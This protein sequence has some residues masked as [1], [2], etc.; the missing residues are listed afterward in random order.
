MNKIERMQTML[1]GERPDQ[2]PAGFWFHFAESAAAGHAMAQAHIDYYRAADPDLLKVMND[3]GYEAVGVDVV[4]SPADWR[5]LEPAP[6]SSAP[7]QAQLAGLRELVDEL[8]DEVL[9]ATTIFNPY[10]TGNK[11]SNNK[12]TEHVKEDP[13]AV[14]AG[15]AAI[16]E[17]LAE[18]SAACIAAGAAGIY[19]SAQGGDASRFTAE[20]HLQCIKPH[21][22]A[23]LD[24][25]TAAGATCN[26]LHICGRGIRLDHYVDYPG[27]TVNWAPQ[28]DNLSLTAGRDLFRRPIIGGVDER[29]PIVD[30]PREAI[31]GEV[32][33]A[34][35]AMG[36]SGFMVGAGCTLPPDVEVGHLAWAR[37]AVR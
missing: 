11:I 4:R 20:E 17:S 28:N 33:A 29:G 24:A 15:L 7:Y 25:A 8:G 16:A 37:E 22:V 26:I 23:V 31:V 30:G 13:E 27:H 5:K 9:M 1:R 18:F 12:V 34:L 21:D 3:N 19:F 36:S 10:A 32:Q 35:E 2:V 14:S 6:L